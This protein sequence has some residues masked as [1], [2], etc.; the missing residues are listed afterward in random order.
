[1]TTE[2]NTTSY[3][4]MVPPFT[5]SFFDPELESVSHTHEMDEIESHPSA[6]HHSTLHVLE[7]SISAHQIKDFQHFLNECLKHRY[8]PSPYGMICLGHPEAK[9]PY[10]GSKPQNPHEDKKVFS[11]FIQR[12]ISKKFKASEE[13]YQNDLKQW[14]VLLNEHV[15]E[16]PK[17]RAQDALF[18]SYVSFVFGNY[19][20]ALRFAQE[21]YH[22]HAFNP[23]A[24]ALQALTHYQKKD[25]TQAALFEAKIR[26][27]QSP[28]P[29]N[30]FGHE[31][32]NAMVQKELSDV[33]LKTCQDTTQQI[34]EAHAQM[35]L[36]KGYLQN[37]IQKR[38][39][40][41]LSHLRD[42]EDVDCLDLISLYFMEQTLLSDSHDNVELN[43]LIEGKFVYLNHLFHHLYENLQLL[44]AHPENISGALK[45]LITKEPSAYSQED[46]RALMDHLSHP[47]SFGNSKLKRAFMQNAIGIQLNQ[48][49]FILNAHI[50]M[51]S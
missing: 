15:L 7:P 13:A 36:E 23:H 28:L 45:D 34:K 6:I 29:L 33:Y 14:E 50:E 2:I 3:S 27:I 44:K 30:A 20:D 37:E 41:V 22:H 31:A 35:P 10:P 51:D 47:L 11:Q 49:L 8:E 25:I 21:S 12:G 26:Q 9:H 43:S 19:E 17:L 1:M 5:E 48:A 18:Q 40:K 39:L 16:V 42:Q 38:L 46:L 32:I 24:L 4:P